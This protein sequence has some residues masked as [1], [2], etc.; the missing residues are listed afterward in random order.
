MGYTP[1][2][3]LVLTADYSHARYRTHNQFD[4]SENLLQ[5]MDAKADWYFRQLHFMG[6]YSR[7]LQGFGA[8]NGIPA[9]VNSFYVGVFR[10][11]HF[12]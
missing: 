11:I 4:L 6:G 7:L 8:Q 3:G 5:Q 1:V 10:S 9:R 12:F 2:R